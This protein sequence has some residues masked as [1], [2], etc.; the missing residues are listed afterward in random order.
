MYGQ[1]FSIAQLIA[2]GY[3]S[4]VSSGGSLNANFDMLRYFQPFPCTFILSS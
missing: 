3:A 1:M 2:T 4:L